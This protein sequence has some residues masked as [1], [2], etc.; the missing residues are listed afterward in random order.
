MSTAPTTSPSRAHHHQYLSPQALRTPLAMQAHKTASRVLL[1]SA[2][3]TATGKRQRYETCMKCEEEYD[4]QVNEKGMCVYHPGS[5]E[6]DGDSDTWADHD[7]RCHGEPDAHV[8]DPDY[9]DG[10]MWDCCEAPV[11]AE[12]CET[13][14]HRPA[15]AKKARAW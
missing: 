14:R 13:D 11:S 1:V 8:D 3:A 4:V 12:G 10:F 7:W 5:K 15:P 6:V 2:P 9:A